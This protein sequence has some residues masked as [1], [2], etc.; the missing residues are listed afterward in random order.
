MIWT[1]T[2]AMLSDEDDGMLCLSLSP[3]PLAVLR[4]SVRFFLRRRFWH[5]IT[6]T[7][8]FS[9]TGGAS[10][11]CEVFLRRRFWH[12]I[13]LIALAHMFLLRLLTLRRLFLGVVWHS[14]HSQALSCLAHMF[15]WLPTPASSG[16]LTVA[17]APPFVEDA[18]ING[19]CILI[20]LA[21]MF[22]LAF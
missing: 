19:Y 9:G 13:T 10:T 15:F 11:L 22:F 5:C 1:K 21:H 12:C 7:A 3:G 14:L 2:L 4:P 6:L 20:A 17:A 16:I 8:L 18:A